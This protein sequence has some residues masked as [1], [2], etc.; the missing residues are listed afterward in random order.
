MT[1]G[2]V[3]FGSALPVCGRPVV[4]VLQCFSGVWRWA[5]V[6]RG[7]DVLFSVH[8]VYF[9]WVRGYWSRVLQTSWSKRRGGKSAVTA[10]KWPDSLDNSGWSAACSH[11]S[12]S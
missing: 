2:F 4:G 11:S 3:I 9:L 12:S 7:G 6:A 5:V 1:T 10:G 8:C